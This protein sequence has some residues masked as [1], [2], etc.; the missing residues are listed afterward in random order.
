MSNRIER[1]Q[2][3]QTNAWKAEPEQVRP[4]RRSIIR[5]FAL[6]TS[7]HALPGI[8]RSQSKHNRIFWIVSFVAFTGIMSYFVVQ[9][10]ISYFQYPTQTSVSIVAQAKEPFPAVTICN[11]CPARFDL[12]IGPFLNY[13]NAM[14]WTNTTNT[15]TFSLLQAQKLRDYLVFK[16]NAGESL[17]SVFFSLNIMLMECTYNGYACNASDFIPFISS[18]YGICYT[19]NARR[20]DTQNYTIRNTNDYGG[21]GR[22]F[23]RLYTHNHLYVPYITEGIVFSSD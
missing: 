6:N 15:S 9:S 20:K 21:K 23:L 18:T 8:A 1:V 19:F 16:I 3:I 11:Y 7:T 14:N 10:I 13:T 12:M 17:T 4:R 5:E 22:L 2:T